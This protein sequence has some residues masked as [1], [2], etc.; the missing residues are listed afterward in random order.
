MDLVDNYP[1]LDESAPLM[2]TRSAT[3]WT[4]AT[5]TMATKALRRMVGSLRR[6]PVQCALHSGRIGGAT[7]LAAQGASDIQIQK[8]QVNGSY[9]SI[10]GL[11]NS[12][13]QGS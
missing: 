3:G 11:C 12:R 13:G 10:H 1:E 6:D 5:R 9:C 2:Q 8:E 4:M 7:Q